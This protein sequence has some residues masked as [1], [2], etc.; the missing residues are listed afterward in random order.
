ML[1]SGDDVG[2]NLDVHFQDDHPTAPNKSVLDMNNGT[3]RMQTA[4]STAYGEPTDGAIKPT[5]FASRTFVEEEIV[6][7]KSCCLQ[8]MK[9]QK[10]DDAHRHG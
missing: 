1:V 7:I 5:A 8:K 4:H 10:F 3:R 6:Q 9:I 2:G